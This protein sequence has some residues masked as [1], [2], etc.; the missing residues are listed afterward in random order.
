MAAIFIFEF[1]TLLGAELIRKRS[2][3]PERELFH[4]RMSNNLIIAIFQSFDLKLSHIALDYST[5][6]ISTLQ[7]IL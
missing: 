3:E 1:N 2:P 5:Y 7:T 4:V 6:T